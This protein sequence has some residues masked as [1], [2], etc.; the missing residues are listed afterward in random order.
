MKWQ[1]EKLLE[2]QGEYERINSIYNSQ[3]SSEENE[4]LGKLCDFKIQTLRS[5]E[6]SKEKFANV[7][8]KSQ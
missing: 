7:V 1:S 3:E 4:E 2:L 5:E 8:F 6:K